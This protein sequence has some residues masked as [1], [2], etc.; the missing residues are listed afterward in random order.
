MNLSFL[1][2][3]RF[4]VIAVIAILVI[5]VGIEQYQKKNTP[6]VYDTFAVKRGELTQTVEATGKIES[7]VD[8]DLLFEVGG[9]IDS[10]EVKE[11]NQVKMGDEL[12]SLR[13]AELNAAVA[14]AQANLNQK[15]AGATVEDIKYYEAAVNLA[16]ASLD[17]TKADGANA[18]STAES[19]VKTAENNLNLASGGENSQIVGNAY[20]SAV[21][22]LKSAISVMDNGLTQADNILGVDN[23]LVNDSFEDYLSV[24]DRNRLTNAQ[25]KYRV[26][27]DKINLAKNAISPLT[28]QSEHGLVDMALTKAEE[29]LNELNG[30][31]SATQDALNATIAIGSLTQTVLD[32]K[33]TSVETAS[34]GVGANYNT[35][36]TQKQSITT[37]KNSYSTYLIAYTKA[38]QDLANTRL[39]TE[40]AVQIK[41][42]SYVQAQANLDAKK[43]PPR[44]VDVAAY[45][46]GLLAAIANRDKA[47]LRSPIDGIVG[48]VA[49]KVGEQISGAETMIKLLSPRFEIT[50]DVP[51]TDISKIKIGG[52]ADITLDAFNNDT[53]LKGVITKVDLMATEIQDVVY[54]QVSVMLDE[55]N[56]VIKSGMTA[57]IIFATEKLVDV[58]SVPSR[59]VRVNDQGKKVVDV[60]ENNQKKET[61]VELGIKADDGLVEI[62]SGLNE[63]QEI[64]LGEKSK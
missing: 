58:I 18:V 53:V 46:A 3:K 23:T 50:V 52:T 51:E 7:A 25:S 22:S 62:I 61:V 37:A 5:I 20:E 48:S 32:A 11:G 35:I 19:A 55:D 54:Y 30:T 1:K 2:K 15:L 27:K 36:I 42:A 24:Q 63:G 64:V 21:A 49:K 56:P 59:A 41:E 45:R 9:T 34:T 57:D 12:A 29:A 44:E 33:K 16:K 4:Y 17:Q 60:L 28:S 43:N 8:L 6:I 10:V 38:T 13:L 40:S 26:A 14:Q 31:L 39:T 47:I